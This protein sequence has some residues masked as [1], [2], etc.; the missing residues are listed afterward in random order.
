MTF[1][2]V[3]GVLLAVLLAGMAAPDRRA[4]ARGSRLNPDAG[5]QSGRR[6]LNGTGNPD[7]YRGSEGTDPGGSW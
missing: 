2:V 6:G 4:T 1:W 5:A 7:A 3:A